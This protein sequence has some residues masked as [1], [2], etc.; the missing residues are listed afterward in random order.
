MNKILATALFATF[1][2]VSAATL[3]SAARAAD[4]NAAQEGKGIYADNCSTCHG[5]QLRNTSN[6]VTF[7]L[8]KLGPNEHGRFVHSVLNGKNDMPPWQGVLEPDQIEDIWAYIRA[9][10]DR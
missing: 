7:D 8:R 4:A 9:T 10:V 6:G 1:P 3:S 5:E 2:V